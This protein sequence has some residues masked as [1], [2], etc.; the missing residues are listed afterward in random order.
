M[1]MQSPAPSTPVVSAT[2]APG[3]PTPAE[4]CGATDFICKGK[5]AVGDAVGGLA[6]QAITKFV[7]SIVEGATNILRLI[8]TW[9][10][11][12]PGPYMDNPMVQTMRENLSWFVW[13]FGVLGFLLALGRM[14]VT[15]YTSGSIRDGLVSIGGLFLN[16]VLATGVYIALIPMLLNAGDAT[17]QWLLERSTDSA[18]FATLAQPMAA[19]AFLASPGTA[20]LL[21]LCLFIGAIANF[22]MLLLRNVLLLVLIVALPVIAASSTTEAGRQAW[23]KANAYLIACLLMKPLAAA[24]YGFGFMLLQDSGEDFGQIIASSIS[25]ILLLFMAALVLPTLVRFLSPVVATGMGGFSGAGLIGAGVGV[26]A[27]AAMLAGSGGAAAAGRMGGMAAGAKDASGALRGA[28]GASGGPNGGTGSNPSGG[29]TPTAGGSGTSGPI[30]FA[31]QDAGV[32]GAGVAGAGGT[33]GLAAEGGE[34]AATAGV[35]GVGGA[36][37]S[38]AAASGDGSSA[39]G[40]EPTTDQAGSLDSKTAAGGASA[41][42][43]SSSA[44]RDASADVRTGQNAATV[45]R[46]QAAGARAA[47]GAAPLSSTGSVDAASGGA[48]PGAGFISDGSQGADDAAGTF[49]T[50]STS[51]AGGAPS[52]TSGLPGSTGTPATGL[53]P[54]AG[55]GGTTS[56]GGTSAPGSAPTAGTAPSGTS[57]L[58][59]ST[60]TPATGLSPVPGSGR[61]P[62]PHGSSAPGSGFISDGNQGIDDAPGIVT[63]PA[64]TTGAGAAPVS[65]AGSTPL[66]SRTA[67]RQMG[68][69]KFQA[70]RGR[71]ARAAANAA[72]FRATTAGLDPAKMIDAEQGDDHR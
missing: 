26:A 3:A 62:S 37:G 36:L 6:N 12:T 60:G 14:V 7:E 21:A 9:W 25:G 58:P 15:A 20:F 19:Q 41:G 55:G 63:T 10:M 22:L 32:A 8:G 47:G 16:I 44:N 52:G 71:M 34:V 40:V 69:Q 5:E 45:Q 48:A 23:K 50:G 68:R 2:P 56:P 43:A 57:G 70:G 17:A 53:G 1:T 61:T 65:G 13:F 30:G 33:A 39:R 38:D 31:R 72:Q 49:P 54:V 4:T 46:E 24:I 42:V 51:T 59:G 35:P 64:P 66:P 67:R 18:D 27:G 28:A 29:G 11:D